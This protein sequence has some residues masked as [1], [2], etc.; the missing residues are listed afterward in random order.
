MRGAMGSRTAA[1]PAAMEWVVGGTGGGGGSGGSSGGNAGAPDGAQPFDVAAEAPWDGPSVS[2]APDMAPGCVP[3]CTAGQMRCRNER[4]VMG[5]PEF[6]TPDAL[7]D[8]AVET[9]AMMR[10][11]GLLEAARKLDSAATAACTTGSEWLGEIGLALRAADHVAD[12]DLRR[13][14]ARIHR[15]VRATWPTL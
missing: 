7:R 3:P 10:T 13:R 9:A 4:V 5:S 12:P 8:F 1:A 2:P 6:D 14:L 15:H 11:A